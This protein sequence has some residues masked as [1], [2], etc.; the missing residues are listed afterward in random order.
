M[1]GTYHTQSLCVLLYLYVSL[2]SKYRYTVYNIHMGVYVSLLPI[3]YII[4]SI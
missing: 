2:M 1:V 4:I 3:K